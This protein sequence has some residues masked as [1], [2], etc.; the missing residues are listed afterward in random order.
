MKTPPPKIRE[1]GPPPRE[2]APIRKCL[3]LM[4]AIFTGFR[5][6]NWRT[7]RKI[8]RIMISEL[9]KI[10]GKI[11]RFLW[12]ELPGVVWLGMQAA[13]H[14][15]RNGPAIIKVARLQRAVRLADEKRRQ[16]RRWHP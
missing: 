4:E 2:P 11:L 6:Q 9:W 14:L 13:V 15:I 5:K 16:E 1:A 12:E 10:R 3:E 7:R 8:L